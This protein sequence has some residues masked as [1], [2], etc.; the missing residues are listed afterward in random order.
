MMDCFDL[1]L[2][3]MKLRCVLDDR[4][5]LLDDVSGASRPGVLTALMGVTGA[6]W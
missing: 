2:E 5:V 1:M 6:G 3:E 4:L